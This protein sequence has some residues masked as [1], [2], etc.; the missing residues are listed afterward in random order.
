MENLFNN[1][2]L[3]S[4]NTNNNEQEIFKTNKLRYNSLNKINFNILL[5]GESESGKTLFIRNFL[6]K[7]EKNVKNLKS[8]STSNN[9]F[10]TFNVFDESNKPIRESDINVGTPTKEFKLYKVKN[11]SITHNDNYSIIDSRGYSG[12]IDSQIM[13][14]KA[15]EY[16]NDW[17]VE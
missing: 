7:V 13:A 1:G 3:K 8:K 5:L 4:I 17:V 12:A 10:N 6:K 11:L 14:T 9:T 16:I 15:I 2:D